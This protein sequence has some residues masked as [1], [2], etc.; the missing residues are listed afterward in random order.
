MM[1]SRMNET[2]DTTFT[3]LYRSQS[4]AD[5]AYES[6]RERIATGE[7]APGQRLTERSL[8]MLLGVSPTPVREALRR[9]EQEGLIER[10]GPRSLT[11]ID[12]SSES[13]AEL[14]YAEIVLRAAIARFAATKIDDKQVEVLHSLVARLEALAADGTPEELLDAARR[15]DE[16]IAE[17]ADNPAL[18]NLCRSVEVVGRSRRL[19]AVAVMQ[20]KRQDVGLRHLQAHRDIVEAL[21]LRD[22]DR[23]EKVVR[24]HLLSS[25]DLLLSDLGSGS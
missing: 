24:E 6:L 3:T 23:A 18:A 16:M 20:G 21:T 25:R 11:V 14:Q 12:H 13:L 2:D 7:L 8:A 17:I 15:F 9:L 4:L 19:R 10:S 22:P 5:Q 1:Q